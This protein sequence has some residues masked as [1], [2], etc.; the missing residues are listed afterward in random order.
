MKAMPKVKKV[1]ITVTYVGVCCK[2]KFINL[3][4]IS[5]QSFAD[6][7]STNTNKLP[8]LMPM[9]YQMFNGH[10]IKNHTN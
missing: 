4:S 10:C 9:A 1:N 2:S 3:R 6:A 8:L 5:D 7:S